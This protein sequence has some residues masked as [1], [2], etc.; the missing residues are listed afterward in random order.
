MRHGRM[1][2]V[3]TM[4]GLSVVTGLVRASLGDKEDGGGDAGHLNTE[5]YFGV[6]TR[7]FD[8]KSRTTGGDTIAFHIHEEE[9][10][11]RKLSEL[12]TPTPAT[13]SNTSISWT[14]EED[15]I[16]QVHYIQNSVFLLSA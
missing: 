3:A 1:S 5:N 10:A 6:Q 2:G 13:E 11:A 7:D 14:R 15:V 4:A 9:P 12:R 16:D 8:G